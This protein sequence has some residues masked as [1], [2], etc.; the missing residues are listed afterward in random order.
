MPQ[1]LRSL[2]VEARR[3]FVEAVQLRTESFAALCRRF[4][5]SR[6]TGYTYWRRFQLG[7]TAALPPHSRAPHQ[8]GRARSVRWRELLGQLRRRH[9]RWG[10]RKLLVR[11]PARGRPAAATLGRWLRE[12]GLVAARRPRPRRGPALPWPGLTV[13]RR[14]NEVW[15]VDFKGSFRVGDGT[16]VNPL[17]V[18]DLFSRYVLCVRHLPDQSHAQARRWFGRLFR[19][20]GLPRVIRCDH[21][22]PWASV[23]VRDLARLSVWWWRLGI[24][25]EF[26]ARGCPGQNGSHEQHH[27]VLRADTARPPART[28]AAQ[29]RRFDRWRRYYNE[30]R[31]HAA[32]RQTVPARHYAPRQPTG[33][34]Q[35]RPEARH[36]QAQAVRRV[37]SSGE[38]VWEGQKRFV[39]DALAGQSIGLYVLSAGVWSVRFLHLELGHLHRADPGGM[40]PTHFAMPPPPEKCPTSNES[41]VSGM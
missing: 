22:V 25:V 9:P 14:T 30:Q 23:G 29:Q 2:S 24:R 3:E 31:P 37:R 28:R 20:F 1:S 12:L 40:R 33:P 26:T 27:R 38:I 17:T 5:I 16:R 21:G 13:P 41:E 15:T 18:R 19:R 10:S 36:A 39:G 32:L 34:L 35:L 7:A 8:H 6:Q 4:Q 11:L